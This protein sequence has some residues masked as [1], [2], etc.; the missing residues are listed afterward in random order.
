[1]DDIIYLQNGMDSDSDPALQP[2]NSYREAKNGNLIAQGGNNYSHES[3]NGTITAF[4]IPFYDAADMMVIIGWFALGMDLLVFSCDNN[5]QSQ[6]GLVTFTDGG[7]GTYQIKYHSSKL[8][9]SKSHL[10]RGYGLVENDA[11]HRA[12]W[13]D[14]FNQPRSL[15]LASTLLDDIDTVHAPASPPTIFIVPNLIAGQQYMVLNTTGTS[16]VS[17]SNIFYGIKPNMSYFSTFWGGF[18]YGGDNIFTYDGVST[19][20]Y[21][22]T[23]SAGSVEIKIVK[24][25]NYNLLNYTPA[26]QLGTVDYFRTSWMKN[27]GAVITGV[28]QYSYQLYTNDGY[29]SS[30]SPLSNLIH[31]TDKYLGDGY[32]QYQGVGSSSDV[33]N[34]TKSIILQINNIDTFFD[35]IRVAVLE[36]HTTGAFFPPN[37]SIDAGYVLFDDVIT[38][39]SMYIVHQGQEDLAKILPSDLQNVNASIIRCRDIVTMKQ[40]QLM[41]N[42]SEREE[43]PK[44]AG[45]PI[46]TP[47][48][49]T[50]PTDN[51]GA[52]TDGYKFRHPLQD[53][54][55]ISTS[56]ILTGGHYV[57]MT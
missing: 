31:S 26:K 5:G 55:G 42:L 22:G 9:F 24:Y 44:Y 21:I 45:T 16:A 12:Y 8:N 28:N 40:R 47:T 11:Y 49:Y 27:S 35:K 54:G 43:I 15:N 10:I 13:T 37:E 2:A 46:I 52:G 25:L 19:V 34:S 39:S 18:T 41:L 57:V 3:V 6:I 51:S 53:A 20:L 50:I 4:T 17:V 7:Q 23:Y 14:Y 29:Y 56:G 32:Q 36:S 48:I 1:M 30:W 38:G 33:A